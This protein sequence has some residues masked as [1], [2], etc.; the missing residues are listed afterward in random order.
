MGSLRRQ[1]TRS[2]LCGV[3]GFGGGQGFLD[4][5]PGVNEAASVSTQLLIAAPRESSKQAGSLGK[6]IL[7]LKEPSSRI[8]G[9]KVAL[10]CLRFRDP[11]G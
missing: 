3:L 4:S 9:T 5:T 2:G 7:F 11:L 6:L 10:S 8:F 1:R